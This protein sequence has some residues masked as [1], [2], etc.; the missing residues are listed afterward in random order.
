MKCSIIIA[1]QKT[2]V[3]LE[4]AFWGREPSEQIAKA[5]RTTLSYL[6]TRSTP[7]ANMVT[8]RLPDG[9]SFSVIMINAPRPAWLSS[10]FARAGE[11]TNVQTAKGHEA[12]CRAKPRPGRPGA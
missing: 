1:G 2:S 9:C 3:S 12:C 4:D 7:T 8:F 6:V 5:R 10:N 11:Y